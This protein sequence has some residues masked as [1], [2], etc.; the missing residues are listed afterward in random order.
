MLEA[1]R[2]AQHLF[3]AAELERRAHDVAATGSG[4]RN[5]ELNRAALAMGHYVAAGAILSDRVEAALIAAAER[6]GLR[7]S[8]ARATTR[9]G[10]AAGSKTPA[11]RR[12]RTDERGAPRARTVAWCAEPATEPGAGAAYQSLMADLIA[13]CPMGGDVAAYLRARALP[14]DASPD[15]IALPPVSEQARLVR[16]L[17][18]RHDRD[19]VAASGLVDAS[20]SC[21]QWPA[22][23]LG[24]VWR[25]AITG[26]VATLQRRCLGAP[27]G[28]AP[29]TVFASGRKV[30]W[31]WGAHLLRNVPR[32]EPVTIVEGAVDWLAWRSLCPY[33]DAAACIALPSA[34]ALSPRLLP[35]LSGRDVF[36]AL[37]SDAAGETA[38]EQCIAQLKPWARPLRIRPWPGCKDWGDRSYQPVSDEQLE[39]SAIEHEVSL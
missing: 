26:A 3:A 35:M 7:P 12:D 11:F 33:P 14:T 31:P 29:K 25:D 19:A 27:I 32:S 23:R 1:R 16:G 5:A 24:F 2:A 9:S 37:D 34:A 10:L 30:E 17:S 28:A 39:R 38:S 18:A 8:E 4:G 15:V 22:H 20:G 13:L 6:A 36:V 21:L